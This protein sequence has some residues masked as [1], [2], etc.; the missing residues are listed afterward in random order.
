MLTRN[1]ADSGTKSVMPLVASA[2]HWVSRAKGKR[3]KRLVKLD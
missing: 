3:T 2:N 1:V